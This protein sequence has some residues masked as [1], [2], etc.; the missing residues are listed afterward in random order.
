MPGNKELFQKYLN[1]VFVETGSLY[2]DGIQQALSAGF[3]TIYS[4]ESNIDRVAK[5]IDRFDTSKVHLVFGKSELVLDKV[6]NDI[7]KPITFW[8]DAHNGYNS[9][10]LK[11]L[12]I[13]KEHYI[14]THIL[15]I[16]DLRDWSIK[17]CGFD[18][19]ILKDRILRINPNYIF[20]LE[21]GYIPND[22]LVAKII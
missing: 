14:K 16:D 6:V 2:G 8:L 3:K 18:I 7:N 17:K 22:I 12:E 10:L 5:C 1:P 20:T 13:I 21:D 11:E 19:D 4:I 15:L 9:P